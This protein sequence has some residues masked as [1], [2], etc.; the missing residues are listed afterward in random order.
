M[1]KHKFLKKLSYEL[2]FLEK[3]EREKSLSYYHEIIDDRIESGLNEEEAVFEMDSISVI[4]EGII[5]DSSYDVATRLKMTPLSVALTIIHF[6]LF[7]IICFVIISLLAGEMFLL[8]SGLLGCVNFFL[9]FSINQARAF[10]VLALALLYISSFLFLFFPSFLLS[11]WMIST[12]WN[13]FRRR[14]I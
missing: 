9:F 12:W 14:V 4:A 8:A 7:A 5:S 1:T 10:M 11:K 2:R 13:V 6:I 3:V